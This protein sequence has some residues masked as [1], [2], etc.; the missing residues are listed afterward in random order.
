M[1]DLKK[2]SLNID[3]VLPKLGTAELVLTL[4]QLGI[5]TEGKPDVLSNKR[6]LIR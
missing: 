2:L 5:K 4:T 3:S 6:K 1:E